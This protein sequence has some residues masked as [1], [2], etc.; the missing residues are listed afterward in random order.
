MRIEQYY[1]F[2]ASQLLKV[3]KGFSKL[4]SIIWA[5][6]EP[7][8]MGAYTFLAPR[9][10]ELCSK[11][12]GANISFRYVGRSERASPAIGIHQLHVQEQEEIVKGCFS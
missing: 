9:L 3:I 2:P 6:E 1:P 8:N 7:K 4:E 12:F 10:Q 5:Q 11:A